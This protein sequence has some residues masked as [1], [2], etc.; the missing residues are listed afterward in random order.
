ML[1]VALMILTVVVMFAWPHPGPY[2]G[3]PSSI[4]DSTPAP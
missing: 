2:R 1:L 3:I 4:F